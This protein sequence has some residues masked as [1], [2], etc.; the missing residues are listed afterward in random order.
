MILSG[1]P[2]TVIGAGVA[3]LAL[4]RAL[5]MRGARVTLLEQ[6][7]AVTDIGAGL[8]ISPNGAAVITALGLAAG[9]A[10]LSLPA[11]TVS[12]RDGMTDRSVLSMDLTRD[13][14]GRGFHLMHRADLIRLL[15]DGAIAAG[16][17]IRLNQKVKRVDLSGPAPILQLD[18]GS[19]QQAPLLFERIAFMAR[20]RR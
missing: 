2:I 15:Q 9:L 17:E 13:P 19:D 16:V 5:A 10:R 20:G 1:K 7:S 14:T 8:Q 11:H 3:G 4:S 6:A 18:D 12:L